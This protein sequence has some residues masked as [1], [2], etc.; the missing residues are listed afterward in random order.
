MTDDMLVSPASTTTPEPSTQPVLAL[1]PVSEAMHP[2]VITCHPGATLRDVARMMANVGI[3]AVVVWGDEEDDSEGVWG[4]VSDLDLVTAAARGEQLAGPAVGAARTEV[5]T[6][7]GRASLLHAA[8]L[9]EQHG[10]THL[11][12]LADDR[13]RPIGILSTLDVARALARAT[14]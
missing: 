3:H 4:I 10:V 14:S 9:M 11:V 12:V 13:D 7:R 1:R 2:G 6:V 8:H 5:V